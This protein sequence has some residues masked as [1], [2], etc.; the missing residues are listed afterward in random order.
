MLWVHGWSPADNYQ[1]IDNIETDKEAQYN[2]S[3]ASYPIL[4]IQKKN[5]SNKLFLN[6]VGQ[7]EAFTL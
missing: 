1:F 4:Y 3:L 5:T 2:I 6:A 7:M